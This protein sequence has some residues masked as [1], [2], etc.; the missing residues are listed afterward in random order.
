MRNEVPSLFD[1][2]WK[3]FSDTWRDAHSKSSEKSVHYLRV[4]SRRLIATWN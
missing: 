1:A 4:N 3:E 2:A